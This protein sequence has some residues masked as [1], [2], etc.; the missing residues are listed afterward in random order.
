MPL[1]ELFYEMLVFQRSK[2]E[3]VVL[4]SNNRPS[5]AMLWHFEALFPLVLFPAFLYFLFRDFPGL[6]IDSIIFG[7]ILEERAITGHFQL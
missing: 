6:P 4:G 3:H 7:Q 1:T 5:R 2:S